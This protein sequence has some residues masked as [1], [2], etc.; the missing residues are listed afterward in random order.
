M[1]SNVGEEMNAQTD[2]TKKKENLLDMAIKGC[3]IG[4][5]F[6]NSNCPFRNVRKLAAN[7]QAQ[8]I[9]RLSEEQIDTIFNYHKDCNSFFS[10][11]TFKPCTTN[12]CGHPSPH[13]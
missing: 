3:P 13:Y 1:I 2:I 10:F 12:C 6:N 9:N 5:D 7:N 8:Y 11:L 4:D